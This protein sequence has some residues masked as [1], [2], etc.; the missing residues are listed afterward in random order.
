MKVFAIIILT[1]LYLLVVCFCVFANG[2]LKTPE[3]REKEDQEQME[4]V[5]EWAR[6]KEK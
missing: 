3:E 2:V 1:L 6:K 4:W 5:S